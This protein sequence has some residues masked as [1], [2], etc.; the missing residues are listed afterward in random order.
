MLAL[1]ESDLVL[2]KL[3]LMV[4][5]PKITSHRFSYDVALVASLISLIFVICFMFSDVLAKPSPAL[6]ESTSIPLS[7]SQAQAHLRKLEVDRKLGLDRLL[8]ISP[9]ISKQEFMTALAQ[10][11]PARVSAF[12][13]SHLSSLDIEV[14]KET[15]FALALMPSVDPRSWLTQHLTQL[16]QNQDHSQR[17]T[18]KI[19]LCESLAYSLHPASAHLIMDI[20]SSEPSKDINLLD[21][22]L[23]TGLYWAS[24]SQKISLTQEQAD[25]L[26]TL[27]SYPKSETGVELRALHLI[28]LLVQNPVLIQSQQQPKIYEKFKTLLLEKLNSTPNLKQLA[29]L[30]LGLDEHDVLGLIAEWWGISSLNKHTQSSSPPNDETLIQQRKYLTA[31]IMG[32]EQ[33][34]PLTPIIFQRFIDHLV[35]SIQ[36]NHPTK[37]AKLDRS[38][39]K[40]YFKLISTLLSQRKLPKSLSQEAKRGLRVLDSNQSI[41][42]H[43][44]LLFD[45]L[46]CYL[47]AL[48][49]HGQRRFVYLPSCSQN[50]HL[51]PLIIRL[52]LQVIKNWGAHRKTKAFKKLFA[53]YDSVSNKSSNTIEQN[54]QRRSVN[55]GLELLTQALTTISP[56]GRRRAWMLT[57]IKSLIQQRALVAQ[58]TLEVIAEHRLKVLVPQVAERL[59][60]ALAYDEYA[61]TV[62][63]LKT[64][65]KIA[66]QA[67]KGLVRPLQKHH[68]S[69]INT[70]AYILSS[71]YEGSEAQTDEQIKPFQLEDNISPAW[72]QKPQLKTFSI[73]LKQGVIKF[74]AS[75]Y[76]FSSLKTLEQAIRQGVFSSAVVTQVNPDRIVFS[77]Q[78]ESSWETWLYPP[79]SEVASQVNTRYV[80]DTWVLTWD[81]LTFDHMNTG[82]SLSKSSTALSLLKHGI[83]A[84]VMSGQEYLESI[85]IGDQVESI[86]VIEHINQ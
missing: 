80:H 49:D 2:M 67:L 22:C 70:L 62:L 12:T 26:I 73:I 5:A 13:K 48:N 16:N 54:T 51:R 29:Y 53:L 11:R 74:R 72:S 68:H 79:R 33:A 44:E 61:V 85:L 71:R 8:A 66:P 32:S 81:P 19:S 78:S 15:Y 57:Q 31:Q 34:V 27:A 4:T 86:R 56:I 75:P 69:E 28:A 23:T 40:A 1:L 42:K 24:Q 10:L 7:K 43:D 82:W 76:A 18:E 77:P 58:A 9:Y 30:V 25:D 36:A 65:E 39:F 47:S 35:Q 84:E 52:G 60:K 55:W 17:I 63:A 50:P 37:T 41:F 20:Y 14:R 3:T 83:I 6:S 64:L 21:S 59:Q 46:K 45:H 38:E